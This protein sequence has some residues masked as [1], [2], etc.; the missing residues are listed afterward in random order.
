[1]HADFSYSKKNGK[2]LS[3]L[4]GHLFI[5]R[6]S[7]RF[8]VLTFFHQLFVYDMY[9]FQVSMSS[10]NRNSL[11]FHQNHPLQLP[12]SLNESKE[13]I[14]DL[15]IANR[16]YRRFSNVSDAVSRKLSTTIGWRTVS[17]QEIVNQSKS[18]CG[19]F[20]RIRLKRNGVQ[21][22]RM[23]LQRL[24][25][26]LSLQNVSIHG[27][28]SQTVCEVFAQLHI[29]GLELERMQLSLYTGVCRQ[30]R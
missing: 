10:S 22:K 20:I 3:L 1:M 8:F 15:E 12:S 5:L 16:R 25:S 13:L 2:S 21:N 26:M 23:G 18:L 7:I 24:R 4:L 6:A 28:A 17:V 30:V 19:Q 29:I 11:N 14:N 27:Q 9:Y